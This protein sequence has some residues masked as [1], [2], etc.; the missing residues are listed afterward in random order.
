[1]AHVS[2]VLF[3]GDNAIGVEW[4][5]DK[6]VEKTFCKKEVILSA[7]S[8]QSPQ[9]LQLSGIGPE[10]ILSKLKIPVVYHS[11]EVGS[12]LQD[13]YQIRGIVKLKDARGSIIQ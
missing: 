5:Q 2:K 6:I 9:I 4:I 1:M 11:D 10:K 8:L 7:G 3:R 13:H 12:N